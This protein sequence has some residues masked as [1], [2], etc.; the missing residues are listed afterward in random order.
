MQNGNSCLSSKFLTSKHLLFPMREIST[1]CVVFALKS[2]QMMKPLLM[3]MCGLGLVDPLAINSNLKEVKPF[4]AREVI[5]G[6]ESYRTINTSL[7]WKYSKDAI[8][9]DLFN[10]ALTQNVVCMCVEE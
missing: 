6:L 2:G 5:V 9:Q 10:Y 1:T 7:S 3:Q 8:G 4:C